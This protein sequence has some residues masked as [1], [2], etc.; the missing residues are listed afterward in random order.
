VTAYR[1]TW[2]YTWDEVEIAAGPDGSATFTF[3]PEYSGYEVLS[4]TS[5]GV[6]GTLS[7]NRWFEFTIG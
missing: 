4:V 6:D 2:S 1:Y 5:V 7:E 3:V